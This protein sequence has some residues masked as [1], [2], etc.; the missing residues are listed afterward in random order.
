MIALQAM[1]CVHSARAGSDAEVR[2]RR[3]FRDQNAADCGRRTADT[4]AGTAATA[5]SSARAAL[6]VPTATT[7]RPTRAPTE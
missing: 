2:S 7:G 6:V 5:A 3:E 1:P 4:T